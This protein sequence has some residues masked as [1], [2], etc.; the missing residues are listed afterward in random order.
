MDLCR[1]VGGLFTLVVETGKLFLVN[2]HADPSDVWLAFIA[3]ATCYVLM[4]RFVNWLRRDKTEEKPIVVEHV[5]NVPNRA[6]EKP[7]ETKLP[8]YK[9]DKRWRIVSVFLAMIITGALFDYP[10]S[11]VL[12]GILLITFSFPLFSQEKINVLILQNEYAHD[13]HIITDVFEEVL[14]NTGNYSI[15]KFFVQEKEENYTQV[16]LDIFLLF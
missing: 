12:L 9:I 8:A 16:F 1:A 4:S 5:V 13:V 3:A 11:P 15:D 10:L 7:L 6:N 14:D 2:K